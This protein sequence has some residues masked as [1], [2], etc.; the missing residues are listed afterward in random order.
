MP[1]GP[2][3]AFV[4]HRSCARNASRRYFEGLTAKFTVDLLRLGELCSTDNKPHACISLLRSFLLSFHV[5]VSWSPE[6]LRGLL[7]WRNSRLLQHGFPY[8]S[9]KEENIFQLLVSPKNR[10]RHSIW[11]SLC[12]CSWNLCTM[13]NNAGTNQL[14]S[15]SILHRQMYFQVSCL[16]IRLGFWWPSIRDCTVKYNQQQLQ[17]LSQSSTVFKGSLQEGRWSKTGQEGRW[18][19]AKNRS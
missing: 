19:K 6:E 16:E 14:N 8:S 1:G 7:S 5:T 13:A 12:D 17:R 2:L 15:I 4:S 9:H 3:L 10:C 18:V 11:L